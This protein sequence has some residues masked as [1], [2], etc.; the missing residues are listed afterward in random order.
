MICK[1]CSTEKASTDFYVGVGS[2]CKTCHKAAM[3]I[4]RLTNPAVQEYD[5][6]RAKTLERKQHMNSVSIKWRK[7]HPEA[8]KAHNAL[9]NALRDGRIQKQP[10]GVCGTEKNVHGHHSDY[11]RPLDVKWLC[12]K[13]HHRIHAIFPQLQGHGARV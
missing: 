5:R 9:N 1:S 11:S 13:C 6:D 10:C 12:A 4:R 7:E 3:K 8:Y 2:R